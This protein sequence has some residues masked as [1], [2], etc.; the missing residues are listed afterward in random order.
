MHIVYNEWM[1]WRSA[2]NLTISDIQIDI[3][4][5]ERFHFQ[6]NLIYKINFQTH[7]LWKKI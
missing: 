5:L 7:T 6:K 2:R 4:N 3:E 1:E